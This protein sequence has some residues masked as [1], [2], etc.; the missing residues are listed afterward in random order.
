MLIGHY[1]S[2]QFNVTK[3]HY[4]KGFCGG[5]KIPLRCYATLP[6]ATILQRGCL[7]FSDF[8]SLSA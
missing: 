5:T 7:L 3:V 4:D 8:I 2:A 1:N 6:H